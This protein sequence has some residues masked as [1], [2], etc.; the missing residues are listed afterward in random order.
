VFE[1][2]Q[3]EDSNQLYPLTSCVIYDAYTYVSII[4]FQ[5]VAA[6]YGDCL[7]DNLPTNQL[8]VS[9]VTDWITR[10]LDNSRILSN[11]QQWFYKYHIWRDYSV[12]IL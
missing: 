4:A 12:K 9:Q 2:I 6:W 7:L 10:G 11:C 5:V 8:A 1:V 3:Y